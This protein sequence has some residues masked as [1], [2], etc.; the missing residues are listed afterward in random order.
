LGIGARAFDAA[1]LPLPLLAEVLG[2]GF[3]FAAVFALVFF[4]RAGRVRRA[5]FC[6]FFREPPLDRVAILVQKKQRDEK[7][8]RNL[9]KP[10]QVGKRG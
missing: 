7:S 8:A 1:A 5:I 10:F 2:A 4:G 3:G 9:M 6:V